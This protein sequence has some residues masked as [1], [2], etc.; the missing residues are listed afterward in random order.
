MKKLV[1]TQ[2]SIF[3]IS[4]KVEEIVS[5]KELITGEI[6]TV[7]KRIK[8][9]EETQSRDE[10]KHLIEENSSKNCNNKDFI[11]KCKPPYNPFCQYF[12]F[13]HSTKRLYTNTKIS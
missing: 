3:K 5:L 8:S 7:I 10:V 13:I 1:I 6:I 11:R 9:V 2:T 12:Q 4:L